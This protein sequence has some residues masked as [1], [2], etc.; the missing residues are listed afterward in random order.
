MMPKSREN[1]VAL[2]APTM[3][4]KAPSHHLLQL[5]TRLLRETR[6]SRR[7]RRR[8]TETGASRLLLRAARLHRRYRSDSP[9]SHRP[10]EIHSRILNFCRQLQFHTRSMTRKQ[11]ASGATSYQ[12]MGYQKR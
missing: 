7:R 11:R 10:Q 2:L 5:K 3:S 8:R 1:L 12:P 6:R 9:D 4:N